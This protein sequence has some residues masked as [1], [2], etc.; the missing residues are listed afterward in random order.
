MAYSLHPLSVEDIVHIPQ[1]IKTDFYEDYLYTSVLLLSVDHPSNLDL[2]IVQ[3]EVAAAA[4]AKAVRAVREAPQGGVAAP[5][6]AAAAAGGMAAK[7]A[8]VAVQQRC[9]LQ[10]TGSFAAAQVDAAAKQPHLHR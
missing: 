9:S 6:G 2:D 1:R 8:A 5:P 10:R 4:A 7:A 3:T